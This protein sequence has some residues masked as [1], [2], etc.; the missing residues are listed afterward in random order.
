MERGLMKM[1]GV[2]LLAAVA[3]GILLPRSKPTT[4]IPTKT[5]S[6]P[7]PS[8]SKAA[9]QPAAAARGVQPQ[10]PQ[11][12]DLPHLYSPTDAPE[13]IDR[14]LQEY[15]R[16]L[17]PQQA[18]QLKLTALNENKKQEDRFVAV[19]LLGERA[20]EFKTELRSIALARPNGDD[21]SIQ[22]QAMVALEGLHDEKIFNEVRYSQNHPLIR[23]LAQMG[24]QGARMQQPFIQNY[25]DSQMSEILDESN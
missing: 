16:H 8:S 10:S 18:A 17:T 1:A 4:D 21:A 24:A 9:T 15:A 3:V 20:Q 13:V 12:K 11:P 7:A 22:I 23:R 6:T 19:Y 25:I 2:L 14:K 5:T